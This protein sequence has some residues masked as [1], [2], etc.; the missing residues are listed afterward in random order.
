MTDS[1]RVLRAVWNSVSEEG[2]SM[3]VICMVEGDMV[4]GELWQRRR[5]S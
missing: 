1:R 3:K 2:G 5:I 4:E